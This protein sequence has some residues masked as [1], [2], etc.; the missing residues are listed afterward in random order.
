MQL[1]T[2]YRE[3][4]RGILT[5][6]KE[7]FLVCTVAFNDQER[8]IIQERGLYKYTISVPSDRPLPTRA[9]D[10]GSAVMRG[11]GLFLTIAG[12]L[13][14]CTAEITKGSGGTD[15]GVAIGVTMLIAGIALFVLGKWRDKQ[16]YAREANPDQTIAVG[17]LL[18]NPTFMVHAYTIAEARQYEEEVRAILKQAAEGIRA[19][20]VVP[21]R[22][23]HEL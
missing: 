8:A 4:K 2:E 16:S 13:T 10:F 17:R 19:N 20:S 15:T 12:L 21:E 11:A 23:T 6:N 14:S 7:F 5:G 22:D 9:G 18:T 1:T 3:E